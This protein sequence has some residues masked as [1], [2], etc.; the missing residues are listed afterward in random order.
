MSL[1]KTAF[2]TSFVG[3]L[4]LMCEAS[5]QIP[6]KPVAQSAPPS[7]PAATRPPPAAPA[8]RRTETM[9]IEAWTLTCREGESA[10]RACSA[11]LHVL[12]QDA[13]NQ[14]RVIFNWIVGLNDGKL[15]T[16]FQ[17]P[18]GVLVQPAV[19]VKM[20]AKD[21]RKVPYTLCN[22]VKCEAAIA[23]DDSFVKDLT[24]AS[25]ADVAIQAADGRTLTFNIN[26]KGFDKVL[27]EIRR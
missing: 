25:T 21:V 27:A 18:T 3:L 17:V 14:P 6:S 16:I 15:V 1:R 12:Q 4:G 9:T 8:I 2:A 22:Q 13:T 24:F 5:A 10:K 7:A 23:M 11:E 20:L 26:T 19:E